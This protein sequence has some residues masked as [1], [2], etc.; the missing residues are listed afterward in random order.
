MYDISC[1]VT[2]QKIPKVAKAIIKIIK[3]KDNCFNKSK[4]FFFLHS[5][6]NSFS[7]LI[8]PYLTYPLTYLSSFKPS[9]FSSFLMAFVSI[10]INNTRSKKTKNII[11]NILLSFSERTI[12]ILSLDN[13]NLYQ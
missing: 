10:P 12:F 6:L 8:K 4:S 11:T 3:G 5:F 2:E 7:V 1:L 9:F 13:E